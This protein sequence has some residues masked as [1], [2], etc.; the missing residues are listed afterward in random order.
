MSKIY[1]RLS[2]WVSWDDIM[3]RITTYPD[4]FDDQLELSERRPSPPR[5]VEEHTIEFGV[6]PE[7]VFSTLRATFFLFQVPSNT[8]PPKSWILDSPYNIYKVGSYNPPVPIS[9]PNS[10][11]KVVTIQ[12]SGSRGFPLFVDRYLSVC[13]KNRRSRSL[14]GFLVMDLCKATIIDMSV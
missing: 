8:R 11:S 12:L 2:K 13:E 1:P 5:Y 7:S 3:I 9:L 10:T 6:S 14:E 4:F